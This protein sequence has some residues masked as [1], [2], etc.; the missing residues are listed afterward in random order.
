MSLLR[1]MGSGFPYCRCWGHISPQR[2]R[3]P[4]RRWF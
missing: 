4:Q 3:R 1:C 2:T